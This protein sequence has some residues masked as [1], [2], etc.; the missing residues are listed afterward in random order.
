MFFLRIGKYAI[1][2]KK[3]LRIFQNTFY[4]SKKNLIFAVINTK[5]DENHIS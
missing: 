1:F 2:L 3:Y 4:I 5:A